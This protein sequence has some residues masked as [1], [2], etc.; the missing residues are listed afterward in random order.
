ML[1][2]LTLEKRCKWFEKNFSPEIAIP[3]LPLI[4]RLDGNNFSSWTSKINKP[5]D[6]RFVDVMEE[7]TKRLVQ[8]TNAVVGYHQSDEITLIL[9]TFDYGTALYH[10]GKKQK[11]LSKL[12]SKASVWFNALVR[13]Y[14]NE[15]LSEAIFDCRFYQVPSLAEGVNQ[16]IWRENDARR[17]SIQ[18]LSHYEFGHSAIMNKNT[19]Q[20]QDM[21]VLEKGINWNDLDPKLKRGSYFRSMITEKPFT[22]EEISNLPPKHNYFRNPEMVTSRRVIDRVDMPILSKVKNKVGTIFY[23]E[24]PELNYTI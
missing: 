15:K 19:D 22:P 6:V 14:F 24:D 11:I 21:L 17:N 23:G 7:L 12:P 9:H 5:W 10:D 4:L 18:M 8:E 13:E 20:M 2:E 16:L 1:N 3:T